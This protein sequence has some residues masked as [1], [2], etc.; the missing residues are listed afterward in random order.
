VLKSSLIFMQP[1]T[2]VVLKVWYEDDFDILEIKDL[3]LDEIKN[4]QYNPTSYLQ[5]QIGIR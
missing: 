3:I 2:G 4:Y 1:H 5:S